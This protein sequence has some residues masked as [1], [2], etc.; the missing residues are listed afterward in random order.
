MK[1][2]LVVLASACAL[3][4]AGC[5]GAP[6]PT[7]VTPATTA[8]PPTTAQPEATAYADELFTLTTTRSP[9][10]ASPR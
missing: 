3:L 4:L 6:A 7:E 8:T 2:G 10:S 5:S 1:T 9:S